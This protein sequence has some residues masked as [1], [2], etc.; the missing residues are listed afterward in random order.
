MKQFKREI[1][2]AYKRVGRYRM[3]ES[4]EWFTTI[5]DNGEKLTDKKACGR[6][7]SQFLANIDNYIE[8]AMHKV[9]KEVGY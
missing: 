6:A 9:T 5:Y 7:V 2:I 4:L 3:V 8:F 1:T